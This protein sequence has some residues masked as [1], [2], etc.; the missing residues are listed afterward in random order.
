MEPLSYL[1]KVNVAIALFYLV[2]RICYRGDTFF[3]VRRYLLLSMLFLSVIYP[4]LDFSHWFMRNATLTDTVVACIQ[5][6][7]EIT[8]AP[9][10]AAAAPAHGNFALW[11]Y[12]L[13]AGVFLLRIIVRLM[14]IVWLRIRCTVVRIE[15]VQVCRLHTQTAPFSFFHWI[16]I[17]PDMHRASEIH[18]IISHELVHVR[19]RHSWDVLLSE[20]LRMACWI[21]PLAWMLKSEIRRNLEFLVDHQVVKNGIDA[22][23]YQYHLLRL[24]GHPSEINITNQ[25]NVSPLKERIIMLNAK[26]SPKMKLIAYTLL[27]PL[28]LLFVIAN[29]ADAMLRKLSDGSEIQSVVEKISDAVAPKERGGRDEIALTQAVKENRFTISGVLVGAEDN[30]PIPGV[31]IIISNTNAGTISD[32]DGKFALEVGAGD[33]LEFSYVG[34]AAFS[35]TVEAGIAHLGTLKMS[36]K[37]E[38]LDEVVVVAQGSIVRVTVPGKQESEPVVVAHVADRD[39]EAAK[40]EPE[41]SVDGEPVFL[42]VEEMP[43]FP[44]GQQELMTFIARTIKYPADA[45]KNG[46]QGRVTCSFVIASNGEI[47]GAKVIRGVDP[48]LDS[49]ALR[50]INAM[51]RWKPGKQRGK[52]VAVEY[53]LPIMF[54]HNGS[55]KGADKAGAAVSPP[56]GV[57]LFG[58]AENEEVIVYINGTI[59]PFSVLKTFDVSTIESITVL[60]DETAVAL[61]PESKDKE[62]VILIT[63]KITT[64]SEKEKIKNLDQ[65]IKTHENDDVEHP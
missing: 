54:R 31:N 10:M 57:T 53:T 13:I 64:D 41:P 4:F 25:F 34:Y 49:E 26:Q 43:E 52:A 11:L 18:E 30:R 32:I 40:Q 2:Y 8:V 3:A 17:N 16:F 58:I 62:G 59:A 33:K 46:I 48:S 20:T 37:K 56:K 1:L 19:Q 51:P 63:T 7:P 6:M 14:Q 60:K 22:R 28:A 44:G 61:F 21:N 23:S 29:N 50:V 9:P 42:V 65:K 39:K 5:Y 15:G 55:E 47:S 12:G 36:R 27:L 35:Y 24:A 45:Q 38:N